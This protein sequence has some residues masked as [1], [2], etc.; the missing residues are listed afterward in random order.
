MNLMLD[1]HIMEIPMD[2]EVEMHM[3]IS[4]YRQEGWALLTIPED[5]Y[6]AREFS[7]AMKAQGKHIYPIGYKD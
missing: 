4:E 3:F 1:G 2:S 5:E 6:E 7:N